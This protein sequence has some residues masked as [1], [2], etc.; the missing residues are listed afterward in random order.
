[1][2]NVSIIIPTK[3]RVGLFSKAL[4]SALTQSYPHTEIIVVDDGSS[5]DVQAQYQQL[6]ATHPDKIQYFHLIEKRNGHGPNYS[7]NYGVAQAT[8]EY[9]AFLDDDDYWT[10]PHYLSNVVRDLEQYPSGVDVIYSNQIAYEP[11]GTLKEAVIWI[12]DIAKTFQWSDTQPINVDQLLTSNGFAHMNCTFM[13]RDFFLQVGGMDESLAYEGDRDFYYRSIDQ[14][15]SILYN[16]AIVSRHNIPD[17]GKA[18]NVSTAVNAVGKILNRLCYIEKN[19]TNVKHL[20]IRQRFI[21]AKVYEYKHL[22]SIMK[23]QQSYKL[24]S[25]YANQA[26]ANQFTLKWSLY[27]VYLSVLALIKR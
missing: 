24:A 27:A 4:D 13:R 3:N 22:A 14:A 5:P 21:Q 17:R 26:L 11:N 12:E 6:I 9:V 7:R 2:T 19:I 15:V 1:M 23:Q 8:G 18:D 25:I 16:P 10:D 20:Q